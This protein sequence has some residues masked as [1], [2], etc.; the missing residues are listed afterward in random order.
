MS[1]SETLVGLS[2]LKQHL[3]Y[4]HMELI[5]V[6][7]FYWALSIIPL[8]HHNYRCTIPSLLWVINVFVIRPCVH[9]SEPTQIVP[10]MCT[11]T[12]ASMQ[13]AYYRWLH[14]SQ[15]N[16]RYTFLIAL[17]FWTNKIYFLLFETSCNF[18]EKLITVNTKLLR[19]RDGHLFRGCQRYCVLGT[20]GSH[21]SANTA[22]AAFSK[23][24]FCLSSLTQLLLAGPSPHI[25][26]FY[27]CK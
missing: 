19:Y 13:L 16:Y 1:R 26:I 6:Q 18:P 7:Y 5:L 24:I 12:A 23:E 4:P 2:R 3:V 9:E 20:D 11:T 8:Y 22:N 17:I 14:A 27:V 21:S 10:A 25:N 15:S